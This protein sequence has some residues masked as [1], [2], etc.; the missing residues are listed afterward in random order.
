MHN[1]KAESYVFFGELSEDLSTG[2]SISDSSERLLQ[3]DKGQGR[4]EPRYI[5]VFATKTR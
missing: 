3:T 5:G 2:H 1:L 4:G